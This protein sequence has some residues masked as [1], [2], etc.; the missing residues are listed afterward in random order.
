M[1]YPVASLEALS[2]GALF[3]VDAAV[4]RAEH[5][6]RVK[7]EERAESTLEFRLAPTLTGV[8]EVDLAVGCPWFL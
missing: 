1:E 6:P 3:S 5:R 2:T 4:I 8:D 7:P